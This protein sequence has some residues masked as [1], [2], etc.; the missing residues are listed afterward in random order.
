MRLQ[1]AK[2]A[3]AP[4][5]GAR[6]TVLGVI[7]RLPEYIRMLAGLL[8]DARVAKL[9]RGLVIAAA[10]YIVLPFD[11]IPDVIPFLGEVDDVVLLVMALQRLVDRAG[12]S[13]LLDH[14]QGPP[15]ALTDLSF[16]RVLAAAAFFLPGAI[17]KRL[18]K[19]LRAA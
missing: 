7:R 17:T 1:K 5:V 9:D 3:D 2:S 18:R 13:V 4:R 15:E 19:L 11:L 14:W 12:R 6:R 16:N 10:A 8:G